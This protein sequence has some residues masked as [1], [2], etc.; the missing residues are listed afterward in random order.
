[1]GK[2]FDFALQRAL[3]HMAQDMVIYFN[4]RRQ[5][6]LAEACNRANGKSAV[7]GGDGK[8]IGIA[9]LIQVTFADPEIQAELRQ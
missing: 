1:L 5:G 7:R 4:H 8:L 3:I 6:T 2:S 9:G